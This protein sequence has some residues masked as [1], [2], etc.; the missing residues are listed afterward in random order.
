MTIPKEKIK[1]AKETIVNRKFNWDN[2]ETPIS[3]L[4][5]NEL[6]VAMQITDEARVTIYDDLDIP[7]DCGYIAENNSLEATEKTRRLIS[8]LGADRSSTEI[9]SDAVLF[10]TDYKEPVGGKQLQAAYNTLEVFES[11][12]PVRN[13][14]IMRRKAEKLDRLLR[15]DLI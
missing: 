10:D 13:A 11:Y 9:L 8:I 4:N 7:N 3:L 6:L 12:I 2:S 5:D 14:V 1:K 15:E